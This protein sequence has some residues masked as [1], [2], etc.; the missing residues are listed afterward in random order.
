MAAKKAKKTSKRVS[1]T[2]D[3]E[4]LEKLIDALNIIGAPGFCF[5]RFVDDPAQARALKKRVKK[6]KR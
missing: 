4:T 2:V 1:L 3:L 5:E 6:T